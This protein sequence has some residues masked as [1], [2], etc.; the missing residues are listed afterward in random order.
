MHGRKA[1]FLD[2]LAECC[3]EINY[4]SRNS[5]LLAD[6]LFKQHLGGRIESDMAPVACYK[7]G[8]S[9]RYYLLTI[10]SSMRNIE[11]KEVLLKAWSRIQMSAK[12]FISSKSH[13]YAWTP[14]DLRATAQKNPSYFFYR[15]VFATSYNGMGKLQRSEIYCISSSTIIL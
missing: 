9:C 6:F 15:G 1:R 5:S 11:S 13:V 2:F 12:P 3:F 7:N 14:Y 8:Q 10:A 4:W